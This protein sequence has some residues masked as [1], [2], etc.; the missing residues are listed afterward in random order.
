MP[1]HGR[2]RTVP[3]RR[4]RWRIAPT[5]LAAVGLCVVAV[6]A[7]GRGGSSASGAEAACRAA[8]GGDASRADTVMLARHTEKPREKDDG[9]KPPYGVTED[10]ERNEHALPVRGRQRA[11]APAALFAPTRRLRRGARVPRSLLSGDRRDPARSARRLMPS[12]RTPP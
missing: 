7:C 2:R 5:P 10:G 1:D 11:G 6:N 4:A 12:G 9:G 8:T 3:A